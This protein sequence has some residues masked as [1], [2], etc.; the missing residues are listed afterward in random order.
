MNP[1]CSDEGTASNSNINPAPSATDILTS[2]VK[3]DIS[4]DTNDLISPSQALTDKSAQI[5]F[6][7]KSLNNMEVC[8]QSVLKEKSPV[9]LPILSMDRD[10]H[11]YQFFK[12][13]YN[14]NSIPNKSISDEEIFQRILDRYKIHIPNYNNNSIIKPKKYKRTKTSST[15]RTNKRRKRNYSPKKLSCKKK[16]HKKC[17]SQFITKL[18][19]LNLYLRCIERKRYTKRV[20]ESQ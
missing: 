20:F 9:L 17:Y 13:D 14:C 1:T 8:E 2:P 16:F 11:S 6:K 4:V 19:I 12:T 15:Y 3:K 18:L 5:P 7:S 10:S